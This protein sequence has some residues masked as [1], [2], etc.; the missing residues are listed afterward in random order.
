[1]HPPVDYPVK[2]D[3]RSGIQNSEEMTY[4]ALLDRHES[5][6]VITDAMIQAACL[7]IETAQ[8]LPHVGKPDLQRFTELPQKLPFADHALSRQHTKQNAEK[9]TRTPGAIRLS[10]AV[11]LSAFAEPAAK[12]L[13]RWIRVIS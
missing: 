7:R 8:Q 6:K 10:T 9:S 11:D 5:E 3:S 12:A 13:S 1:M 2:D 4:A